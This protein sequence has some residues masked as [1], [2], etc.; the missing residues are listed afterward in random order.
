MS[1]KD[2]IIIFDTTLRD[3]EQSPGASMTINEKIEIALMLEQMNVD[4]IEAGFA[5]ASKTDLDSI[6]EISKLI[7]NSTIC[8]LARATERDISAANESIKFAERKRIHTFIATSDIHLQ[9]KLHKTQDEVLDIIHS[10]VKYA[11]NLCNNIE[12]SAEDATRTDINYLIRCVQTAIKAGAK[13]INLPDTVG[14]TTPLEYKQMFEEVIKNTDSDGI[15]FST[16]CHNDLGMATANALC[17]I[18][19][20]ARQVECAINGMGERA[21]NTAIEEF[22]MILKTRN[23]L[24]FRTN[25]DAKK[26][27][28]ASKLV[29]KITGFTIQPNKAIVGKNAFLHESGIHQD[30]MLKCKNTYEIISPEDVGIS[31]N[32]IVL[33]RLSGRAALK[34]KLKE[35]GC[36]PNDDEL[37]VMFDKFKEIAATKKFILDNDIVDI[38]NKNTGRNISQSVEFTSYQIISSSENEK[39]VSV[40]LLFNNQEI[41]AKHKGSGVIDAIF[42]AINKIAGIEPILDSFTIDAV[43]NGSDAIGM[44][45]VVLTYNNS[46]FAASGCDNDIVI[47]ASKAYVNGINK[48]LNSVNL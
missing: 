20:G 21:G 24:N 34:D 36:N 33:G 12:W 26:I 3:G 37:S 2:N 30:G 8:S 5:F 11:R 46:S 13:T 32:P 42:Q 14:F 48:V 9:H 4:I 17:G 44:A 41:T 18:Q 40:K 1:K 28:D 23:D 25:I 27:K 38:I 29:Q 39:H 7:K 45:N 10:S 19:G 22:I 6:T 35:F 47:A 16:H 43:S 15:I 31:V